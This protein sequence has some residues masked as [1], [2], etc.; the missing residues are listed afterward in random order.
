MKSVCIH[1]ANAVIVL[2]LHMETYS[3]FLNMHHL[4]CARYIQSV[5]PGCAC[6]V[7]QFNLTVMCKNESPKYKKHIIFSS[8]I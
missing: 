4:K 6:V 5:L 7:L 1:H 3:T 2:I 8:F